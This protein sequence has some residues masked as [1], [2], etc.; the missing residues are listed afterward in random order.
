MKIS[1]AP[2]GRKT[3]APSRPSG[4]GGQPPRSPSHGSRDGLLSTGPPGLPSSADAQI[5]NRTTL[6]LTPMDREAWKRESHRAP[7]PVGAEPCHPQRTGGRMPGS[8]PI[9]P[10]P[11]L[12]IGKR[13]T[14]AVSSHRTPRC[15]AH[16]SLG[17][18]KILLGLQ[19]GLCQD[20]LLA[21]WERCQERVKK[22]SLRNCE[23]K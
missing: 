18:Q 4:A 21:R 8:T 17:A 10:F 12:R 7:S 2:E 16:S 19:P 3:M 5:R 13:T 14:K 22:C 6:K 11:G 1:P 9:S 23:W 15:C 20:G